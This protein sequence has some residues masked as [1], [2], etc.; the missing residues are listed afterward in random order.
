MSGA[1]QVFVRHKR[2]QARFLAV[3]NVPV[4]KSFFS[5]TI[6]VLEIAP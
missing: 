1:S 3:E 2:Q 4:Q 6:L 5:T